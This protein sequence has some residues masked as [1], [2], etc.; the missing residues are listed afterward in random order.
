MSVGPILL[1][2]AKSDIARALADAFAARGHP[3]QL[4]ARDLSALARDR[5]DLSLRH[6]VAVSLHRFDALAPETF[7]SF[8]DSLPETPRIVV[9]AVGTM[10]DQ[11]RAAADPATAA[12]VIASNLTGPA[13]ALEAA[14][15]RLA[16]LDEDTA[17]IGISSVA[18]D[19]GRARNYVYGAAKAGFSAW[20]S[21]MSQKYART[22]VHVMTVRPGFV[23]TA[24][25][26]DMDLPAALTT[27][28]E[29][30][31]KRILRSLD[32]RRIVHYDPVWRVIMT[33]IR[34]V[35][36]RIFA[37]MKF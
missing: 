15:R 5:A 23:A 14:A 10:P 28:P 11:D 26:E 4:A 19:R 17:V 16:A 25:T 18:G 2:G 33:I 6:G 34:L 21:G 7:E 30:L 13:L 1:L 24:M 20:L 36:D 8:L 27:T 29:A 3:L 32:R 35:P 37:R 22:R 12:A 31:A 9:S